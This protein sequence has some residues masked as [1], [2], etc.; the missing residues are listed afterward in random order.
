MWSQVVPGHLRWPQMV[1]GRLS[2]SQVVLG[3]PRWLHVVSC[4][5]VYLQ[6]LVVSGGPKWTLVVSGGTRWSGQ[7]GPMGSDMPIYP[8]S[9]YHYKFISDFAILGWQQ[10]FLQ[11]IW[12][13]VGQAASPS[14][15]SL[16]IHCT[17]ACLA[18]NANITTIIILLSHNLRFGEILMEGSQNRLENQSQFIGRV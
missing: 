6:L 13:P 9:N 4:A 1:P 11:S 7:S 8:W 18:D 15:A 5:H 14:S 16:P 3:G 12:G 17:Q 2:W 10:C